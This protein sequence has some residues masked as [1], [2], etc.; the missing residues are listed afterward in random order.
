MIAKINA[1]SGHRN[2]YATS[3]LVRFRMDL[4]EDLIHQKPA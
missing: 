1:M 3:E 4:V 2:A